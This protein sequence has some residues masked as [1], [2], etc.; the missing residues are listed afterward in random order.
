MHEVEAVA[1]DDERKLVCKFLTMDQVTS[2]RAVNSYFSAYCS[3][4]QRYR[5]KME[6]ATATK[7][8]S[9]HNPFS[10]F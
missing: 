6:A 10:L 5:K 4:L 8:T 1:D 9:N 2:V 3:Y 7:M